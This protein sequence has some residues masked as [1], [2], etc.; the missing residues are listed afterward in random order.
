M[1]ANTCGGGKQLRRR[2]SRAICLHALQHQR[3]SRRCVN[4][5]PPPPLPYT[6]PAK[7]NKPTPTYQATKQQTATATSSSWS[8]ARSKSTARQTRLFSLYLD[9]QRKAPDNHVTLAWARSRLGLS[10]AIEN[11]GKEG[12]GKGQWSRRGGRES[13][14]EQEESI[15]TENRPKKRG[16]EKSTRFETQAFFKYQLH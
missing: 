12:V 5:S 3:P 1:Y 7:A 11:V 15:T 2:S 10:A 16:G 14:A 13:M 9:H 6:L 8:A 4:D